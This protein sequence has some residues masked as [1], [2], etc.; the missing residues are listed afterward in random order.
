[1]NFLLTTLDNLIPP[2]LKVYGIIIGEHKLKEVTRILLIS[3]KSCFFNIANLVAKFREEIL[4]N[5]T[6]EYINKSFSRPIIY[7]P[8]FVFLLSILFPFPKNYS[9]TYL[10]HLS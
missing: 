5:S 6:S 1:M 2:K 10:L 7:I 9:D 8:A 3:S 4:A